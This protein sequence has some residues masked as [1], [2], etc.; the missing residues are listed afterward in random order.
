M[1]ATRS[2]R[3]ASGLQPRG[4]LPARV[5]WTRRLLVLGTVLLLVVG[6]ARLIGGGSDGVDSA[7]DTAAAASATTGDPS[8]G[9]GSAGPTQPASPARAGAGAPAGTKPREPRKTPLA[10]PEGRCEDADVQ[11]VPEVPVA[12]GGSPIAVRLVLRTLETDAC[13]WYASA[14]SLTLRIR[15]G[16]DEIWSSRQCPGA[17]PRRSVVVRQAADAVLTVAWSGRRSD[18][19]CSRLTGWA[20]P[21]WYHV[22]AAAL[23]GEPADVQFEVTA[24][25]RPVVERTV[26]PSPTLGPGAGRDRPDPT[27]SASPR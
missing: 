5:Y 24:P 17:L 9:P 16:D 13:W 8:V 2:P 6:L 14:D 11:V 27:P 19:D 10:A 25:S 4:P 12:V 18:D 22:E 21:G 1:P 20:L 3:P 7:A 15:S 26:T 23:S